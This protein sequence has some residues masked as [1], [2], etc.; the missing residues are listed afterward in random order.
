[1]R[2]ETIKAFSKYL[3]EPLYQWFD[4]LIQQAGTTA[5]Q[6]LDV[7]CNKKWRKVK[8]ERKVRKTVNNDIIR[9]TKDNYRL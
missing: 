5:W 4:I 1:M 3:E 2:Y 7:N 8:K 9:Y 6:S